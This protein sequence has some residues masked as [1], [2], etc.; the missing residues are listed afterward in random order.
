MVKLGEHELRGTIIVQCNHY[1][2]VEVPRDN[3]VC[4]LKDY[5]WEKLIGHNYA[6]GETWVD[7]VLEDYPAMVTELGGRLRQVGEAHAKELKLLHEEL[8]R[9]NK[10][11]TR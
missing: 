3:S 6:G 5:Y 9:K 1:R 8:N 4:A 11:L 7:V 2:L 10:E